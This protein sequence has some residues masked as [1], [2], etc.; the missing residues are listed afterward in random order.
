MSAA[1]RPLETTAVNI[2]PVP[3]LL[4]LSHDLGVQ[5]PEHARSF[6]SLRGLCQWL[7]SLRVGTSGLLHREASGYLISFRVLRSHP[8][9]AGGLAVDLMLVKEW[10]SSPVA[11]VFLLLPL[12]LVG[13]SLI[14]RYS[15]AH[16]SR[17]REQILFDLAAMLFY[18]AITYP[19]AEHAVRL[20]GV[21]APIPST[22][23]SL[24]YAV[25]ILLY[26]IVADFG[27]YWLHRLMHHPLLWPVHRWHHS[28]T[29]MS[30]SAGARES[31]P[32]AIIVNLAYMFAW[33]L[34]GHVGPTTAGLLLI[35]VMF[36]ND[37][38]HLNVNW[39][40][41]W[42]EWLIV[43]PR[44]H[45]IH[46]SDDQRHHSKN[47]A[48]LFSFWDRLFGTYI[49]PDRI[50]SKLRFGTGEKVSTP[51]MIIGVSGPRMR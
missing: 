4:Q 48:I 18:V 38:M 22:I 50:D 5:L 26:L 24:P 37:W 17:F 14:E 45:H 11:L 3:I 2:I 15:P 7:T 36:K 39:R 34:L 41:P 33:P 44:Y 29:H 30:W 19:I 32:D 10:L 28:P 27:H 31:I 49:D 23:N 6:G 40:L 1:E 21:S 46:H 25:R 43:T 20:I 51:R 42:L 47:L 16:E 12:R 13:L 35:F 9:F 8:A